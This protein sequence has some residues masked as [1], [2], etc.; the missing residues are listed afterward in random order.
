MSKSKL[1]NCKNYKAT[2]EL[3]YRALEKKEDTLVRGEKKN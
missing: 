1:K 2:K 3:R